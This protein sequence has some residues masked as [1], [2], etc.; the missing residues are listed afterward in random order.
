MHFSPR[1][2]IWIVVVL[3]V[4][5]IALIILSQRTG[6]ADFS[7][8][9]SALPRSGHGEM[10]TIAQHVEAVAAAFNIPRSA[11]RLP[12]RTQTGSGIPE[13]RLKVSPEFSSFEFHSALVR[14]LADLNTTVVGTE[15]QREKNISLQILK[16]GLPVMLVMLDM[17]TSQRQQRKESSH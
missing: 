15:H 3:A 1:T 5:A 9:Q 2:R 11:M 10:L 17:R 6:R 16:D 12:S 8:A 14:A 13:V 7:Q 4:C